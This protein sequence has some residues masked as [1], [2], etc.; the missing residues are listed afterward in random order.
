MVKEVVIVNRDPAKGLKWPAE[1]SHYTWGLNRDGTHTKIPLGHN[2]FQ[3]AEVCG[4]VL[5]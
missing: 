4:A 1:G 2:D 5:C 3:F